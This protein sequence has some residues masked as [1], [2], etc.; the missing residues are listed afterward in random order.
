MITMPFLPHNIYTNDVNVEFDGGVACGGAG[1]A[2]IEHLIAH[3]PR[4]KTQVK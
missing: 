2:S 1:V 3:H 4:H